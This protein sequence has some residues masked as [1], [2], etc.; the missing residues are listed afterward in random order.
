MK[1]NSIGLC[2]Q[3]AS[4]RDVGSSDEAHRKPLRTSIEREV[5]RR[6]QEIF[7]ACPDPVEIRLENFTKYVRRQHLKRFLAMYEVFKVA[8]PVKGSVVECGVFRGFGLMAWAKLSAMLEPENLTRRIYGFD[9]FQGFPTVAAQD[10]SMFTDSQPG[11][12]SAD[13]YDEL[14]E[15]IREYDRDR[16]L[17]HI[18]K[19]ELIRG[20]ITRTVPDFAAAHPHLVVS[21]LYLDADMYEPTKVALEV[22]L[23]RMPKGAVLAFDELDNPIWPGETVAAMDAVGLRNL[24][25]RRM[26]WDPYIAFAVIE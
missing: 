21:L 12:L 26:D 11:D 2:T 19:V 5:G 9:T 25:L 14:Q 22:F 20:D 4:D 24:R 1:P 10:Q 23:P 7:L 18:P 6:V 8:M 13:S 17:G 3:S 15:L 16:F